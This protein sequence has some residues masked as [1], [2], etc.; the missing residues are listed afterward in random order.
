M[1][2]CEVTTWSGRDALYL[3]AAGYEALLVPSLGAN[4][5]SFKGMIN[6][7]QADILRTPLDDETL[8]NDPYAYGIPVLFPAN[9]VQGGCYT[10]DGITYDF[11]RNY[12]NDVH[13]HGVLH[14][15]A[16][17]VESYGADDEKAWC[18][19]VL[20]TRT[21]QTL[22]QHFPVPMRICLEISVGSEG[23]KHVFSVENLSD[24]HEIPVG[25]AYHTALRVALCGEM[26]GVTLHVPL[27]GRCTDDP[28]DRLPNGETIPLSDF[29]SRVAS[30]A[31]AP[32]LEEAVDYL[33]TAVKDMPEAIMRDN[34]RG[35]EAVYRADAENRYWILWNQTATE[36]FIAVEPQTWLSNAMHHSRPAERGAIFVKPMQSWKNECSIFLRTVKE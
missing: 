7:C 32:P 27:Q 26:H 13:I 9:R 14:N 21:D 24:T 29:E 36:G 30:A 1:A 18:K 19:L 33:Y 15:R 3:R 8:L 17:P 12:P 6:G 2:R 23:L 31:G 28:L 35:I 11:P 16:W 34:L 4:V 22:W 10:W 25:L 5:I 20:D